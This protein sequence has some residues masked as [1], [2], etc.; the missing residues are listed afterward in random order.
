MAIEK[1]VHKSRYCFHVITY[2]EMKRLT[3]LCWIN[4]VTRL[5]MVS[6]SMNPAR[7]SKL[8]LSPRKLEPSQAEATLILLL[9]AI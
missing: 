6:S 8:A 1:G 9:T 7:K 5:G 3:C 2:R 4:L